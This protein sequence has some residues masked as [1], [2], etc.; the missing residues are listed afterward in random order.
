MTD[1]ASLDAVSR[2]LLSKISEVRRL[3]EQKRKEARST[4]E[5]HQLAEDVA[6]AAGDVYRLANAEELDGESDSPDPGERT[7]QRPGDWT[8]HA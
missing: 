6:D 7:E 3:E 5:F 2:A 8:T 1:D 4:D